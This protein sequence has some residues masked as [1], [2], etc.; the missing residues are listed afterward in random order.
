MDRISAIPDGPASRALPPP[1]VVVVMGVSGCGKSTVGARLAALLGWDF[2]EGD[3]FHSADHVARMRAGV[4]LSDADRAP[5][6]RAIAAWIGHR[7]VADA[8]GI[9]AC[10]ALR[11]SYRETLAGGSGAVGFA[12][13]K[14]GR[15]TIA[16]R[17]AARRGHF[18][19][20]SL[21]DSQFAL[22]EEPGPGERTA[23]VAIEAGPDE[24]AGLIARAFGLARA[25]RAA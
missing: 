12:Y 24:A 18:M 21:L 17:V 25:G 5:W 8:P 4:A 2:A 1:R 20:E 11:R 9:V 6:L 14:G 13:L 16:R 19:P 3:G 7:L 22:L 10:S 23:T 15:A